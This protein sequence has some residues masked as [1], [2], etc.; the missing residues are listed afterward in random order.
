MVECSEPAAFEREFTR[1]G[2][3]ASTVQAT[4]LSSLVAQHIRSTDRD[5]DARREDTIKLDRALQSF[6]FTMIPP[7]G[8]AEGAYCG[9]YWM[10]TK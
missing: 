9:A 6:A 2:Y 4:Y 5:P 3:F 10:R 1:L 7:P 8:R